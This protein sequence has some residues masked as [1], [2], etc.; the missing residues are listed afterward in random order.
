MKKLLLLVM[1]LCF[2]GTI[3]FAQTKQITG[4]VISASDG[5]SIPGAT[6]TVKGTTIGTITN[7]N[8]S[9]TLTVPENEELV[10]SFVGMKTLEVPITATLIYNVQLEIETIGV[11]EV[12]VT[13]VGISRSTKA[14]GYAVSQ[15]DSESALQKSEPDFLRSISG[16]IPGVDIK[17]S[18]G[19]P[20]SATRITI[21]GS[22]SFLGN[23]QPLFVVDGVPYDNTQYNTTR[24]L[25]SGGSYG[26]GISSLDPN[27]IK[28]ISV[29]RGASA[30]ALYGSR[31]ANGVILITT[32]AGA[33]EGS[34]TGKMDIQVSS[35]V[36]F[37]E[38][39]NLPDYQ[40]TYGNGVDFEYQ[41]ANGSWGPKFSSRETIPLWGPYAEAF[42]EWD[43]EVPY[44][45]QPDNVQSLFRT[46]TVFENSISINSG[47]ENT[48]LSM[49]ASHLNHDG[50][51]PH[52][53]FKRS[54][55]SIGGNAV[56]KNGIK[57]GG[58]IA[59]SQNYQTG[60]L[61]GE[62]QSSDPGAAS[63]FARTLW[64]GRTWDM[65]LPYTHPVT[66]ESLTPNGT[67]FDH[68]LWSWEHNKAI[69][70]SN[71]V[72]AGFNIGY[73]FTDWLKVSY[74]LGANTFTMR[75]QQ[76]TDIGSRAYEGQGAIIDDDVWSQEIES[77]LIFEFD[78]DLNS[79]INLSAHLGHNMNQFTSDRQSF[80]GQGII[81]PG[82]FDLDNTRSVISNGG[83][84]SRRRL[85]GV[86]ADAV[87][88][89]KN[90]L[91][92]TITGRN[93]WSS[94]LPVDNRSY[95]YPSV[96]GSFIF[97]DAFKMDDE[98][99]SFGKIR[100]S[101]AKVG[102]DAGPYQ[103]VNTYLVNFGSSTGL[104]GAI[105]DTDLP[106][107]GIPGMTVSNT[108]FDPNLTPEFTTE[109]EF[110]T[111][112]EFFKGDISLDLTYYNRKSTDQ[113]ARVSLPDATGFSSLVTNFGDM[114]NKGVEI[115][116][117]L[118][119][120]NT[121]T[122]LKWDIYATFTKNISE[123]LALQDGVERIN[124]ENLFAEI[125]PVIEVGQPYGIL[126]GSRDIRDD[127][128]NLLIDPSTGVLI[129]DTEQGT[130][131]DPNPD[132]LIG[133]TNSISWKG[134]TL[135]AVIDYRHGGDLYS[136]SITALLGRGVTKDTED[137]EGTFIIPG[138][139]G[140]PNTLEPLLDENG[141]KI[142][143]QTQVSMNDLYF[144]ESFAINSAR[145]WQVYDATVVRLKEISLG[146]DIPKSL[147]SKTPFG[148]ASFS[149]TGRNL[150]FNAP[151]V[152]EHTNFDPEINGFGA[153]NTQGIEFAS[154]PSVRRYGFNLKV[155][156]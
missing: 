152:P 23:N 84:Y 25:N 26:S 37:E 137:R 7:T 34:K 126:R 144:G 150:W 80:F 116:L 44:E 90:F 92:L 32:K 139:Y 38:I 20:G 143:N 98:F 24:Q 73:E 56:L 132:F 94:T 46:G 128:G 102:S 66:G 110:G 108:S 13:A 156:F 153:T 117:G 86:F 78:K 31:A 146:Y 121:A 10:F 77:T 125:N 88:G 81:S 19:M 51:I 112:L 151:N 54:S 99:L 95:F 59:F 105:Q 107:N 89:Y 106:F 6:V 3:L 33:S 115:G 130:I 57:V 17:Q 29:L 134:I 82:I 63:S 148:S 142:P 120:I 111:L 28:S 127:Q 5:E 123:V 72:A 62:N 60:A 40:N 65:T 97:T 136:S 39:G 4:T 41:N 79:D 35:S 76:I 135:G 43:D 67:Q 87:I 55:F 140:D 114:R 85:I 138:Y 42:P 122:G 131:G 18:T 70:N 14:L 141:D 8:G 47:S 49:V 91:Y 45:A 155:S 52:S 93:D 2:G 22:S 101:W 104:V 145:E 21:R 149:I 129:R 64:L 96:A 58:N 27:S 9:F 50:F 118:K 16:K 68:P 36:S 71:R 48:N 109:Y 113:I 69:E 11:E 154:V 61:F 30:S 124:I 12:I 103:L 133:F 100:A 1:V 147:L 74:M 83:T 119:P 15:I 75:R 53:N